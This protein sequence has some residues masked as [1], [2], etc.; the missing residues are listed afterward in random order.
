MRLYRVGLFSDAYL[1][2]PNGV[3]TSVYLLMRELRR[4]G[5]E[6]WV[7]APEIPEYDRQEEWV[8]RVP[9]V[10]YPFFE[11]QRLAMPSN[12]YLPTE[13]EIFHTHDPLFIGI[14]GARLAYRQQSPHVSTFHTHLE[15][16]AHY[17]PGV[18]TLE[19]YTGLMTRVC[20]AFYNR[21]DLVI[22]PTQSFAKL[23][24]NFYEV[25]RE[26]RVIP[27]GIDTEILESAPEPPSPWPSG[28]RRLLHVGRLGEEKSVDV[29]IRALAEIRQES[30]AHLALVGIGPQQEELAQ[31][32]AELG[33][34]EHVTFVGRVPYDRIGGYYRMAELFLFASTTET[35]GLVVWEAEAMGVPVVA[36]RAEGVMDGVDPGASGYLVE[37]GDHRAMAAKALEVLRDEGLRQRL[38]LGA[39]SFADRRSAKRVAEAI[40]EV[41]DQATQLV[42]VEPRRLKIP[43]P[44]LPR[45]SLQ[46]SR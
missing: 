18:A 17:I 45:N 46:G 32:S 37:V 1:P 26:I 39:R 16:Y 20:Q 25:E 43:F 38:S 5:H 14:W 6:A 30:D 3:A 33:L 29:V 34:S 21:A 24:E 4:M 40:V 15:K 7:L 44:R 31:L 27:T 36:V 19:K 42:E 11:G 35:Q 9:S 41:Y 8:V 12:R 23:V 2:S 13:F 22:A 28:K 10:P